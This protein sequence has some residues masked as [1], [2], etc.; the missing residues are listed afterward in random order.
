MSSVPPQVESAPYKPP[1][2]PTDQLKMFTLRGK[3]VFPEP[4]QDCIE[5]VTPGG[6]YTLLGDFAI[7]AVW[8]HDGPPELVVRGIPAPQ[9]ST[10]CD[11]VPFKVFSVWT[12]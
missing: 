11:G 10:P 9:L 7:P 8:G 1:K 3:M 5:F 6:R 2:H 4:G 12:S